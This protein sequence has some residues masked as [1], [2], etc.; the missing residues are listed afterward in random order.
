M[1]ESFFYRIFLYTK[2]TGIELPVI[3]NYLNILFTDSLLAVLFTAG[4]SENAQ[5]LPGG[6]GR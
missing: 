3:F 5:F 4:Y 1:A 6:P 2:I